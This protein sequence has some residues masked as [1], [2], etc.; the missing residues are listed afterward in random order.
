[1]KSGPPAAGTSPAA[2]RLVFLDG[3]R[4]LAAVAVVL[5]H[6]YQTVTSDGTIRRHASLLGYG[7]FAVAVFIV[8]SGYS[9]GVATARRARDQRFASFIRRRAW[10][11]LP[12]YIGALALSVVL[13]LTVIGSKT[14]TPWDLVLPLS[15]SGVG[16]NA[17]LLQDVVMARAPNHLFWSIAVEWHLYFVFPVLVAVRRRLSRTSLLFLGALGCALLWIPYGGKP[18]VG[19]PPQ[20][21]GL[22]VLGVA[23]AGLVTEQ[24]VGAPGSRARFRPWWTLA[25]VALAAPLGVLL[26]QVDRSFFI[27]ELVLGVAVA[28]FI[29]ALTLAPRHPVR[30]L[31]E[32]RPLA[33]IGLFSYSLYLTHAPVLQ[34]LWEYGVRPLRLGPD[35]EFLVTL[36]GATAASLTVALAFH[37][38]FERPFMKHRSFKAMSHA[39]RRNREPS[40]DLRRSRE[41]ADGIDEGQQEDAV[42]YLVEGWSRVPSEETSSMRGT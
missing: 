13:T 30:R 14:G 11:I 40:A 38:V 36:F 33:W 27:A 10:R 12:P 7:N 5:N 28:A 37:P 4:A 19:F 31:L 26:V 16:V 39:L 41:L 21:F 35:A 25:G 32:W 23:A 6:V 8:I 22:F 17:L 42:R 20:F 29:V 3:M 1:M 9:L 24:D 18:Y 2:G 34:I 15:W